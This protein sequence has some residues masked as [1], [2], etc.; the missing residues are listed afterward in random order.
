MIY[1][2]VRLWKRGRQTDRYFLVLKKN[3]GSFVAGNGGSVKP[4]TNMAKRSGVGL[5]RAGG[6]KK[7]KFDS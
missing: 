5:P 3:V 2:I 4:I 7:I 6:G 1:W